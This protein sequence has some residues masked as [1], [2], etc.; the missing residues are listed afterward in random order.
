[1]INGHRPLAHTELACFAVK[2][3]RKQRN[4]HGDSVDTDLNDTWGWRHDF[5]ATPRTAVPRQ[6]AVA[7]LSTGGLL[8]QCFVPGPDCKLSI[9][10]LMHVS[11]Q[12]LHSHRHHLIATSR[13]PAN[14]SV[15]A[16]WCDVGVAV[17]RNCHRLSEFPKSR[18]RQRRTIP[19]LLHSY[20]HLIAT[21]NMALYTQKNKHV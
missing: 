21:A 19:H 9:W 13:Q 16:H 4:Y 15:H 3:T 17:S 11:L 1:M 2:S 7:V 10:M 14:G 18:L 5:S 8:Q 20:L 6:T 12:S